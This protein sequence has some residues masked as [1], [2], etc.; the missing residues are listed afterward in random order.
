MLVFDDGSTVGTVGG[1]NVE[2]RVT[3]AAAAIAGGAPALRVEHH[4]VRDLAMCCGGSMEFWISPVKGQRAQLSQAL[5]AFQ[6]R[7]PAR[8]V[9]PFDGTSV[10]IEF[11]TRVDTPLALDEKAFS[12][13]LL[14]LSRVILFGAGHVSQA[15]GPLLAQVGFEVTLCDDGTTGAID[16]RPLW[17]NAVIPSFDVADVKAKT[18]PVG[19]RDY[20]VIMTRDHAVDEAV[21]RD[22]LPEAQH[23]AYL[24]V[25]GSRGKLARFRKRIEARGP[26]AAALWDFVHGPIGLQIG[27][28]TPAEIAVSVVAE[29][30][31]TRKTRRRAATKRAAT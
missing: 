5:A 26:K 10:R 27:A 18:G 12:Y 6:R 19:E 7:E 17:A 4:L 21:L 14:P 15:L 30:I 23:L 9:M 31:A 11:P 1:G 8:L 13:T 24:G 29:L 28:E 2:H 3:T 25:I 20:V 16:R 22:F